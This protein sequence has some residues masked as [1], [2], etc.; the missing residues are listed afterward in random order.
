[1]QARGGLNAGKRWSRPD[2]PGM[3]FSG[4]AIGLLLFRVI[5]AS[6]S[7]GKQAAKSE[8]GSSGLL[9]TAGVFEARTSLCVCFCA[10]AK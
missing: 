4:G 10:S 3:S 5:L 8:E 2:L 7:Q 9:T 1:M 6:S